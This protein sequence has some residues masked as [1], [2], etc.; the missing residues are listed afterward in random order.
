MMCSRKGRLLN[1]G[2]NVRS[3][4]KK[5]RFSNAQPDDEPRMQET[6]SS[7]S[8]ARVRGVDLLNEGEN[9]E[10]SREEEGAKGHVERRGP[11]GLLL[12]DRLSHESRKGKR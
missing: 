10:E 6:S 3:F 12:F 11:S 5:T 8:F 9:R 4:S 2:H 7:C 1:V